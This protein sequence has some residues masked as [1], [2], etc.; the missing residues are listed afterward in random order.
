MTRTKER[1]SSPRTPA[2]AGRGFGFG[3]RVARRVLR[4]ARRGLGEGEG[5][6]L[7]LHRE[8]DHAAANQRAEQQLLGERFLDMLLDDAA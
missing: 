4:R 3:V 1:V 7:V 8:M 6:L 2:R 5:E